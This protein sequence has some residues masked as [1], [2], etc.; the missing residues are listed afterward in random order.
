MARIDRQKRAM[1]GAV[2]RTKPSQ[3][4]RVL[5]DRLLTV[6]RVL[7]YGCGYGYDAD[8]FGWDAYDPFYR[9]TN[10]VG[11]YDTIVCTHVLNALTRN[12][13]ASVIQDVRA[14]LADEGIAYLAVRR[15]LPISGKSGI[16]HSLQ[17]YIVFTLPSIFED[18]KLKIYEMTKKAEFDDKTKD[19]K[20]LRDRR[21]DR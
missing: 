6:G 2:K 19:F 7:D 21:R 11:S 14:L 18:D 8:E 5:V 10:L 1:G 20:S 4:A 3:A 17:N 9:P 13:R 15:D 16:N 12:N